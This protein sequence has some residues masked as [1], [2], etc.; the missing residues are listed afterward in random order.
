M[1]SSTLMMCSC[2]VSLILSI[3]AA[4]EVDL[5][6]PVGPVTRTSPRGFS[7]SSSTAF[8]SP[9]SLMLFI[10]LGMV[11]KAAPIAPLWK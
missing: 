3:M 7:V 6:L 5:P 4:R 2:L 10:S 8:G 9:S 1:G 11:R